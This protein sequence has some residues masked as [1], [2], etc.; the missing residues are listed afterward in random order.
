[1]SKSILVI[2][3]PKRCEECPLRYDYVV[4]YEKCGYDMINC[5][6]K[7]LPSKMKVDYDTISSAEVTEKVVAMGFNACIDAILKGEEE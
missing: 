2:D 3:T 5:P 6:L 7:P 4:Y 1:M